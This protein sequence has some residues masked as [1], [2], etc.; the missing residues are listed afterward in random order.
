MALGL[1]HEYFLS[2]A[3][4]LELQRLVHYQLYPYILSDIVVPIYIA[5]QL[6]LQLPFFFGPNF[7]LLD[8]PVFGWLVSNQKK[9]VIFR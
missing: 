1:P 2:R 9:D 8:D 7:G 3:A 4:R 5:I 6:G